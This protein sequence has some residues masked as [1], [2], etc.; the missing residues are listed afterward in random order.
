MTQSFRLTVN[1]HA[2]VVI[3]EP[4]TSLLL[5]LRNELDLKGVRF[6]CGLGQCGACLV[7]AEGAVTTSCD[8][9]MSAVEGWSIVTVE[10]LAIGDDLH[11]VQQAV[12]DEQAGQC[13][14]CLSGI[15]VC[16]ATLL[17]ANPVP[18]EQ[19]VVAALDRNLC[20]CGVQRRLVRAVLSAGQDSA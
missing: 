16:A 4:D 12:L 1:G 15:L 2:R 8:L 13:G 18:D 19:E 20:R 10:G 6:G 7:Q 17:D 3:A 9:P 11:R 14:Y 5:V